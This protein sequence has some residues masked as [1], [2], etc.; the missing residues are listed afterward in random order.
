ALLISA[1]LCIAAILYG[2]QFFNINAGGITEPSGEVSFGATSK[3]GWILT[4]SF[5]ALVVIASLIRRLYYK[6]NGR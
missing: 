3:L 1:M 4:A 5:F 2:I 6:I